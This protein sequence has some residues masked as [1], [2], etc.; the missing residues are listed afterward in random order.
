MTVSR[1]TARDMAQSV[2][3]LSSPLI[4]EKQQK[5]RKTRTMR[6]MLKQQ[7]FSQAK[8]EG[9]ENYNTVVSKSMNTSRSTSETNMGQI[10]MNFI[11]Q[12]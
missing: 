5:S 8:I 7:S 12:L 3:L 2:M 4:G 10:K 9:F 1:N 6:H 11:S